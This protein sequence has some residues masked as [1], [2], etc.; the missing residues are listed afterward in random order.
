MDDF[1]D[2]VRVVNIVL[3]L[4]CVVLLLKTWRRSLGMGSS[5]AM[6]RLSILYLLTFALLGSVETLL[7]HASAAP[8]V[9]TYV[10]F[11]ALCQLL[12]ALWLSRRDD[13]RR[14]DG[15]FEDE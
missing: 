11:V 8:G 3:S 12:Y 15:R 2:A 13:Q 5:Y 9:R 7:Q 14:K 1:S 4:L 10:L 6:L